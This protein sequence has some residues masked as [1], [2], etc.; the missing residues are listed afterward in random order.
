MKTVCPF[1]GAKNDR[2]AHSGG[3]LVL[4]DD[5]DVSI[6]FGC[7]ELSVFDSG[8]VGDLRKPTDEEAAAFAADADIQRALKA[9]RKAKG[10]P[11]V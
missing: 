5:G 9:W 1:C 7:A 3:L 4:P 10:T 8:V 6:C 11:D 2:S